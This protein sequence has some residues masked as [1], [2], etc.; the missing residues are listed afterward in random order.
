MT[1]YFDFDRDVV[2]HEYHQVSKYYI[3]SSIY[4]QMKG[5]GLPANSTEAPPPDE[6]AP[7]GMVYI[8]NDNTWDLVQDTF[9]RPNIEEVNYTYTGERPLETV[10]ERID[11]P[12]TYFP[13]YNDVVDYISSNLKTLHLSFNYVRIQKKYLHII[14][15]FNLAT[16]THNPFTLQERIFDYKVESEFFV[17]MIRSFF[18]EMVQLTYLLINEV[19]D[20]LIDSIG[21]LIRDQNKNRECYNVFFGDNDV[22]IKDDSE[23]LVIINNLS[24]SIKHSSLHY[25]SYSSYPL[26]PNILSFYKKNNTFKNNDVVIHN[27]NVVDVFLGFKANFHRIIKNQQNYVKHHAK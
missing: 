21:S 8:F 15:L 11:F 19:S 9:P 18:D 26:S 17:A 4:R 3:S 12:F 6:N 7:N 24:N 25:E 1:V 16:S 5:T 22:Y 10:I 20:N 2:I 13:Q 14:E 27:H 23:Y